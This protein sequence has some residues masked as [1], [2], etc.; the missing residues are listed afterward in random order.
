MP[1]CVVRSMVCMILMCATCCVCVCVCVCVY[2]CVY[3]CVCVC[4]L[5]SLRRR[6]RDA[7]A[8]ARGTQPEL[9]A[10]VNEIEV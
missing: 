9:I 5:Q 3:V 10:R 1:L 8:L 7:E 6:L 2:V 4:A